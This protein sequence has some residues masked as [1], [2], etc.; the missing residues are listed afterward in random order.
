MAGS[1]NNWGEE[2]WYEREG[3]TSF[4]IQNEG[5]T[6]MTEAIEL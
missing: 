5:A 3:R 1:R 2:D 6:A 4:A